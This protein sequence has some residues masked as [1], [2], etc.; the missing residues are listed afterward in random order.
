MASSV[1]LIF[2]FLSLCI[3]V[4]SS[5]AIFVIVAPPIFRNTSS[6]RLA[7]EL[8]SPILQRFAAIFIPNA[9]LLLVSFYLQL[10]AL[11]SSVGLKL[12]VVMALVSVGLVVAAYE[13][14]RL[15]NRINVLR[16]RLAAL[17]SEGLENH[18]D[19]RE[20]SSLHRQSMALF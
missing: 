9:F 7:G 4:G 14:I 5:F 2:Q 10:I 6:A 19:R 1:L 13:K 12:R 16:R 18:D 3:W 15:G 8:M 20:F 11:D 17:T